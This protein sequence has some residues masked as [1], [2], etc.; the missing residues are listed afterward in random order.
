MSTWLELARDLKA[1]D[2]V[3]FDCDWD[4]YPDVYV[5]AGNLGT[6]VENSLNEMEPTLFIRPD[7]VTIQKQVK[8]W[9]GVVHVYGPWHDDESWNDVAPVSKI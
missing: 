6:V 8:D 1:G 3:R 9:D 5:H 7:N 2:R 4:R